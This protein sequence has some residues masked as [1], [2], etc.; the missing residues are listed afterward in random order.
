MIRFIDLWGRI[1]VTKGG[2]E[3]RRTHFAFCNILNDELEE[4]N[5]IITWE[6]WKS[7]EK[8][9]G[10][11]IKAKSITPFGRDVQKSKLKTK[12]IERYH[13][14]CPAWVFKPCRCYLC[15][16]ETEKSGG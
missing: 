12:E 10:Y 6:S 16:G 2:D 9:F 11:E 7:F 13:G 4:F 3:R 8:D 5:K 1:Y 14:L 15:Q